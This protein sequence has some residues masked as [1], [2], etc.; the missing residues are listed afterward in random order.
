MPVPRSC[1]RFPTWSNGLCTD[2]A[3]GGS[4]QMV[5]H[6]EVVH[7]L[8]CR[9]TPRRC[10]PDSRDTGFGPPKTSEDGCQAF[11]YSGARLGG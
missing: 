4:W 7:P 2:V 1:T 11:L 6:S 5:G 9:P 3:P 8:I 10:Q